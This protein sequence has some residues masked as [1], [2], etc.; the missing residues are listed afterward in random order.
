MQKNFKSIAIIVFS[1][2]LLCACSNPSF[3]NESNS[4]IKL[5]KTTFNDQKGNK[6]NKT[7]GKFSFY[8]PFG[9]EIKNTYPNNSIVKNG[10]K[11]YILFINPKEGFSSDVVYKASVANYKKLEVNESFRNKN[12]IGY[13]L[14]HR[15]KDD[16][17]EVTV[18]VGGSKLTTETKTSNL[19]EEAKTMMKIVNSVKIN[20]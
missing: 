10:S 15:M 12:K 1:I 9:F 7:S 19:Q 13:L 20:K 3:K 17:C 18:G 8:L 6:P 2:F 16:N 4:A 5:V 11:T 14:I